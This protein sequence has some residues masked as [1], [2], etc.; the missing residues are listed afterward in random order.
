MY[1]NYLK[2]L[3]PKR[4]FAIKIILLL[5]GLTFIPLQAQ[6]NGWKTAKI[7]PGSK[8]IKI[9]ATPNFSGCFTVETY[10]QKDWFRCEDTKRK[11][12]MNWETVWNKVHKDYD[13]T[14]SK[15]G[16]SYINFESRVPKDVFYYGDP[17]VGISMMGK[18]GKWQSIWMG[19]AI[20]SSNYHGGKLRSNSKSNIQY[21]INSDGT[22]KI[23][24]AIHFEP[25]KYRVTIVSANRFN[26]NTGEKT[27]VKSSANAKIY[28]IPDGTIVSEKPNAPNLKFEW[29]VKGDVLVDG[30]Y[31]VS[32]KVTPT[33]GMSFSFG[34]Q[35]GSI[36]RGL[37]I[38]SGEA[39]A[40][41]TVDDLYQEK[42]KTN[43]NL[44]YIVDK[45]TFVP[46]VF[47]KGLYVVAVAAKGIWSTLFSP[48]P[49]VRSYQKEQWQNF[50]KYSWNNTKIVLTNYWNAGINTGL[51]DYV[52]IF[53]GN[54][55]VSSISQDVV[56]NAG[57]A[58]VMAKMTVL[59]KGFRKFINAAKHKTLFGHS[60]F[61]NNYNHVINSIV[62][63]VSD[64]KRY[65][66]YLQTRPSNLES[67]STVYLSKEQAGWRISPQSTGYLDFIS[68]GSVKLYVDEGQFVVDK[69]SGLQKRIYT[70]GEST[71]I[72]PPKSNGG[73]D[74]DINNNIGK[75]IHPTADAYVYAYNYR[76]WNRSNRGKYEQLVAGWNPVGGESRIYI[77]FDL[78]NMSPSQLKKAVFKI[79]HTLTSG[80]SNI[81]LG[82]YRVTDPWQEGTDTYHSGQVEKAAL[83]GEITWI[84]QPTINSNPIAAFTPG[85]E[86]SDW[87]SVDITPLV[88]QWLVGFKNYG[89]V[90][91][92]IEPFKGNNQQ[93]VYR[94][95]SREWQDASKS[96][97]LVLNGSSGI[98]NNNLSGGKTISLPT[99]L[100][101]P[102]TTSQG[103]Y[104]KT[105]NQLCIRSMQ[106]GGAW[107][108]T[109]RTY[110]FNKDYT[111]SFDVKL[112][113]A[114]N[115]FPVL[116]SDGFV[117]VNIDWG[118]DLSHY[119][120]G[121]PYGLKNHLANLDVG[122]WYKIRVEAHPT[123]GT[124][125]L[126][127][128]NKLMSTATNIKVLHNYHTSSTQITNSQ[129][130]WLGDA[131][132]KD[133]R[134][135]SYNRGDVC[136]RNIVFKQAHN[137]TSTQ[138]TTSK[139][140]ELPF[141][142]KF[143]NE[144]SIWTYPS[145]GYIKRGKFFWNVGQ[146][147]K[148]IR[149]N[150]LIPLEN[151]VIEFDG[152]AETNGFTIHLVNKN[153]VGYIAI[154]GGWNNSQSGSDIG[155]PTE[156]RKLVPGKV[157]QPK[158]WGH[159]KVVRS[160]NHLSGYF[161]GRLIFDR[162]VS[163]HYSGY[164][165]LYFD[166]WN[167]LI[168]I[169]NIHI[170]K[171]NIN[172]LH[173][174]TNKNIDNVWA[175]NTSGFI[176]NWNGRNWD[177]LPGKAQD[178]GVGA[179]GTV[180]IIGPGNPNGSIY[181]L[182]N[183]KFVKVPGSAVRVDVDQ[184]GIPWI[185][186]A[187]GDIYKWENK[188]WRKIP[189]GAYDIG[190]GSHGTVWVIGREPAYGGYEIYR[191]M[192]SQWVKVPGAAVRIDVG[193]W[194]TPWVVNS[195]G[196]IYKWVNKTWQKL[197]GKAKDISISADGVPWVIG[198]NSVLGGYGIYK[199]DGSKWI[200]IPGGAAVISVGGSK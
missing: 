13:F 53:G 195:F 35:G 89:F 37:T 82:I 187:N 12:K 63:L 143:N 192:G 183:T 169:D 94:F 191:W 107:F 179:N 193:P 86:T 31:P 29:S 125:D 122:R 168:G 88:K 7:V 149:L 147:F 19:G 186:N 171:P 108:T 112:N 146:D 73:N 185:V 56:L 124:F 45:I 200:N 155:K 157:W 165:N 150:A 136:W 83:N 151:I 113:S 197:P 50:K 154:F 76:N 134:G 93:S 85:T 18:D 148:Q 66:P 80:N 30:Q 15:P 92:P 43:E 142:E 156:N 24:G 41:I 4:N 11:S 44:D 70:S 64:T 131:D 190:I 3:P 26:S 115:H 21:K 175:L 120:P 167:A 55:S 79:Y 166:S 90:I 105:I 51:P 121:L 36:S 101:Q 8:E 27:Y 10:F 161:N 170:Y 160:G 14:I 127:L 133:Y 23:N 47:G 102:H 198:T 174:S 99:N 177:N 28:F 182:M 52:P 176:Y 69:I 38:I 119:Q 25:G 194:G 59:H 75:K 139:L 163:T 87:I 110:Q 189:G 162:I 40:E 60:I 20:F 58:K 173:S 6:N 81:E 54:I 97:V 74:A 48:N 104:T 135:G 114:D 199:W 84:N 111:V 196:N 95:Y 65:L 145:N 32:N 141:F 1:V 17:T 118:R 178:I 57:L 188:I 68:D 100:W 116:Y 67:P 77:K 39:G 61:G 132:S 71:W 106:P 159:Y 62:P 129:N 181:R 152:Y 140:L 5:A 138:G 34:N 117:F 103:R 2:S 130:I 98:N 158:V 33:K 137:N 164:G 72:F 91:R 9:N 153:D 126:Y 123:R 46:K 184:N 180:W 172:N 144:T 49:A 16:Y 96:P 109:A 128:D 22:L 42:D 78:P